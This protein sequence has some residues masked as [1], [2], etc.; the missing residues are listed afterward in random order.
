MYESALPMQ[1]RG[2]HKAK[3][4][5][6]PAK[7][8]QRFR[9]SRMEKVNGRETSKDGLEVQNIWRQARDCVRGR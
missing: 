7:F 2:I 9:D 1:I 4:S 5:A 6:E 3:T 8:G